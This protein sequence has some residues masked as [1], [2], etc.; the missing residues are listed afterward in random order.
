VCFSDGSGRRGRLSEDE[1]E[2]KY[3]KI[4]GKPLTDMEL[5]HFRKNFLKPIFAKEEGK[6]TDDER[7]NDP[8]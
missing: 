8:W 1:W 5:Q 6:P 3:C 4:Y 2:T 7:N